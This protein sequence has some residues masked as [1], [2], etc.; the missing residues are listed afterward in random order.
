MV[1]ADPTIHSETIAD[2]TAQQLPDG[3]AQLLALDVPQRDVERRERRLSVCIAFSEGRSRVGA[4]LPSGRDHRG[5]N[6]R[7]MSSMPSAS[8][9]EVGGD[10]AKGAFDRFGVTLEGGF[11]PSDEPVCG[12]DSHEQPAW[13]DAEEL[14]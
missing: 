8:Q 10:V 9:D 11:A 7:Q 13:R 4:R 1:T 2:F 12:F 5:R 3:H 6:G 14:N